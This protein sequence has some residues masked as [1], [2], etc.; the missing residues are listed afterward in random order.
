MLLRASRTLVALVLFCA[1]SAPLAAQS[2]V[3]QGRLDTAQGPADGRYDFIFELYATEVGGTPLGTVSMDTE[4]VDGLFSIELNFGPIEY[5]GNEWL[6]IRV[7]LPEELGGTGFETLVPRQRVTAAPAAASELQDQWRA[8]GD[9][10]TNENPAQRLY[11]NRS[12]AI[13][14]FDWFTVRAPAPAGSFGGM[15]IEASDTN[16]LPFYGYAA[17]GQPLGFS[18]IQPS[19]GEWRLTLDNANDLTYSPPGDLGVPGTVTASDF[20]YDEMSFRTL[21]VPAV[22]FRPTLSGAEYETNG[23][24]STIRAN[25]GSSTL[26]APVMLPDRALVRRMEFF[27]IDDNDQAA[28]TCTLG[29]NNLLAGNLATQLLAATEIA[30]ATPMPRSV[31]DVPAIPVSIDNEVNQYFLTVSSTDWDSLQ[32]VI[33]VKI[34]YSVIQPD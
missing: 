18:Y 14:G 19:T 27:Y 11:I 2:F 12:F 30:E 6:E 34:G 4:V 1:S 22:A 24:S 3:Y 16:G 32:R 5:T 26:V 31:T 20:S 33:A 28:M 29:S 7:A 21:T 17:N 8:V 23:R 10:L 9:V 15:Y 25:A 13:N